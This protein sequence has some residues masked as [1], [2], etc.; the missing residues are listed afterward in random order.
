MPL[1]LP[2][3]CH[4]LQRRYPS[5]VA[6]TRLREF[7]GMFWLRKFKLG[8]RRKYMNYMGFRAF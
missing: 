6:A 3:S 2:V 1:G 5:G 8:L 4:H 7:H